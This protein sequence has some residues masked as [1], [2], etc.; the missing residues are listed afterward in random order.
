M[1]DGTYD[2]VDVHQMHAVLD[3]LIY[4]KEQARHGE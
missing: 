4:Q 2:L 3:E 1:I